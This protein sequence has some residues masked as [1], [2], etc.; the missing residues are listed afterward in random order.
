MSTKR[1]LDIQADARRAFD[2]IRAGGIAI[3]PTDVG[4]SLIGS[5]EPA[6][7]RIFDTKRHAP[8]K[9]NAMLGED[10]ARSTCWTLAN[11]P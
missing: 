3:L 8:S 11:A 2:A 6:L 7:R 4:Y 5:M 10:I 1:I 9:L